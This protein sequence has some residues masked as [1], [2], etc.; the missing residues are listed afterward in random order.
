MTEEQAFEASMGKY[1]EIVEI[2]MTRE[3]AIIFLDQLEEILSK[4]P[5]WLPD[6]RQ[7][8]HEAFEMARAGIKEPK[9]GEW[10]PCSERLPDGIG[11]VLV[12]ADYHG[13]LV[14]YSAWF[15]ERDNVFDRIPP[16]H[17]VIAWKELPEPYEK[18]R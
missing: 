4:S 14:V 1:D 7:A 13:T 3:E 9:Q 18:E 12:T 5:S 2:N 17:I 6:A 8:V 16:E 10:I 11:E 15:D